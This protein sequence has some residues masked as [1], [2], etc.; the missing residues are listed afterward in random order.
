[1]CT[2]P[3]FQKSLM[4]LLIYLFILYVCV[5]CGLYPRETCYRHLRQPNLQLTAYVSCIS[6]FAAV[7]V[8]HWCRSAIAPQFLALH[9]QFLASCNKNCHHEWYY[10]FVSM[11]TL[12]NQKFAYTVTD[13]AWQNFHVWKF[14][15]LMGRHNRDGQPRRQ[16][17]W[18]IAICTASFAGLELPL[19]YCSSVWLL[20][21]IDRACQHLRRALSLLQMSASDWN[22]VPV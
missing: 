19:V 5:C 10:F 1:M 2:L 13:D 8:L 21:V 14:H 15:N 22:G 3:E 18:S 16:G 6:T 12:E 9:P 4:A 20:H 7:E 11:E 17:F